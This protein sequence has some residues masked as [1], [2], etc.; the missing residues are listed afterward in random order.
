M[1]M[2]QETVMRR[3]LPALV[4][5]VLSPLV[6]EF[7]LGATT[8]SRLAPAIPLVFFYGG[9][10]II[11]R[12]LARRRGPGWGRIITLSLAYGI[13]EEGLVVQSLFNPDLFMAGKIGGRAL[14]VNWIWSEWTVGY[15][16]VYS[17]AIPILLVELLFSHRKEQPW[18]G[19]KALTVV[20]AGYV[21]SAVVIGIAFR[22][23]IAPGFHT[24]L[25]QVVAATSL[26][27]VLGILAIFWPDNRS[28]SRPDTSP[29]GCPSPWFVGAVSF[30][31]AFA[32]FLLLGLPAP[33]KSG[34]PVLFPIVSGIA[35][36]AGMAVLIRRWSARGGGWSDTHSLAL[37][38]G[39][40]PPVMLFGFFVVTAGNRV[41]QIGQ[42]IASLTALGSLAVLASRSGQA[43][44]LFSMAR[45]PAGGLRNL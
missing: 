10:A 33:L 21:V 36:S 5:L 11:I 38:M 35:L 20:V 32:W 7:F 28:S 26:V 25:P 12:E 44:K 40:L 15:H 13:V 19:W 37:V 8:V 39:S 27:A 22:Q 31:A 1:A 2:E 14:G 30:L 24:P 42:G 6:G 23:I 41:D 29:P 17:I 45:A 18:L 43:R 34:F 3:C 4:L 16:T 9:G